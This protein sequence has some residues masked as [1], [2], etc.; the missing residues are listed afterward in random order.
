MGESLP[1]FNFRRLR[2]LTLVLRCPIQR[3][4]PQNGWFVGRITEHVI[5]L[6]TLHVHAST[7]EPSDTFAEAVKRQSHS[8]KQLYA[9]GFCP[10]LD[11]LKNLQLV[12]IDYLVIGG[13]WALEV[14]ICSAI[15]RGAPQSHDSSYPLYSLIQL[16]GHFSSIVG[17]L[18]SHT[19][20]RQL[21]TYCS[22]V[23]CTWRHWASFVHTRICCWLAPISRS[24]NGR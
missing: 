18:P 11:I 12:R 7:L 1:S 15:P 24:W 14:S 19:K 4:V 20:H 22:V 6:E 13:E 16:S 21:K 8:L 23:K 9:P 2:G 5:N 10:S 17:G 3:T